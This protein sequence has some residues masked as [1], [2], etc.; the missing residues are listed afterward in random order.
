MTNLDTHSDAPAGYR[1][2]LQAWMGGPIPS[3]VLAT[4]RRD[5]WHEQGLLIINPNDISND[6]AR[7]ALV[8]LGNKL[9]GQRKE[10][11]A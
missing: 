7:Q 3:T 11:H 8:T 10:M 2:S 6:H 9:Y 4:L 1:N 5:A